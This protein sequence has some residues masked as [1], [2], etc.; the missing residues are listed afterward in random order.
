MKQNIE[1][2]INNIGKRFTLDGSFADNGINNMDKSEVEEDSEVH[3][4]VPFQYAENIK[5]H[6]RRIKRFE[7]ESKEAEKMV[8]EMIEENDRDAHSRVVKT[9]SLRKMRLSE[10]LFE[11]YDAG[12]KRYKFIKQKEVQDPDGFTDEYV[13]YYDTEDDKYV[14]VFGDTDIYDPNYDGSEYFDYET[15]DRET[16]EEWFDDYEGPG[17]IEESFK[18]NKHKNLRNYDFE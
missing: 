3:V 18:K 2:A 8:N 12:S 14:F 4:E 6:K 15:D 1:E 13:M 7:E 9:D 17:D 11:D 16:A 5:D 10:S